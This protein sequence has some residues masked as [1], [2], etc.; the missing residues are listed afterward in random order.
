MSG[1]ILRNQITIEKNKY[2]IY[3]KMEQSLHYK[4]IIK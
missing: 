1:D 3:E 4:K 2:L